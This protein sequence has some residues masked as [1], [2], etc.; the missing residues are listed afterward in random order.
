M[1]WRAPCRFITP[2]P[3]HAP[4]AVGIEPVSRHRWATISGVQ[5]L[6]EKGTKVDLFEGIFLFRGSDWTLF[7]GRTLA[8]FLPASDVVDER[9]RIFQLFQNRVLHHLAIDH[10]L[11]LKLVERKDADHLHEARRKYLPLR[12]F[13]AQSVLQ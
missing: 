9:N 13:E 7:G 6:L 5:I 8:L 1:M 11:E 3:R 12:Y 10:V 2:L 4:P